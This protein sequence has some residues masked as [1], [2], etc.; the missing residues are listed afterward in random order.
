MNVPDHEA[1]EAS[2]PESNFA[3]PD[4]LVTVCGTESSLTHVTVVPTGT[5]TAAGEYA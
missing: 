2:W 5:V 3:G 4:V 1:P